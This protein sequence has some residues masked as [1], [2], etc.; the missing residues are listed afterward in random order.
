MFVLFLNN[1]KTVGVEIRRV[2]FP[3]MSF[4]SDFLQEFGWTGF[5]VEDK[6]INAG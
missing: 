5:E 6:N 1:L 3:F 4:L 2:I